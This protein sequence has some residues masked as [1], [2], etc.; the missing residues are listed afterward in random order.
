MAA[1][2]RDRQPAAPSWPAC[3]AACGAGAT[4][5]RR[6]EARNGTTLARQM[7]SRSSR[8]VCSAR[9][10]RDGLLAHLEGKHLGHRRLRRPLGQHLRGMQIAHRPVVLGQMRLDRAGGEELVVHA[11]DQT[12]L[13]LIRDAS[14]DQLEGHL[15]H[16]R[17]RRPRQRD[18]G[19]VHVGLLDGAI[20]HGGVAERGIAEQ[21]GDRA[22]AP[23]DRGRP[24]DR[25]RR[26]GYRSARSA[27][28]SS[29]WPCSA[30][31]QTS[32]A[33]QLGPGG[34]S[35]LMLANSVS[36]CRASSS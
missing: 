13:I 23:R 19:R 8:A 24:A 12:A 25:R 1:T 36:P 30:P 34:R 31:W 33:S 26:A 3:S 6:R 35:T 14:R 28:R 20:E 7:P 29:D 17:K 9:G 11:L 5:R 27:S 18:V 22:A 4:G 32:C 21:L 15:R 10:T 16:G 2:R